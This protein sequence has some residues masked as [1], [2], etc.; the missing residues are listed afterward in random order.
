MSRFMR[1]QTGW[2]GNLILPVMAPSKQ[3]FTQAIFYLTT[4]IRKA[5]VKVEMGKEVTL[6]LLNEMKPDAVVVA[7]GAVPLIPVDLPGVDKP[8]VLTAPRC[9]GRKS[10]CRVEGG[11]DRS[12]MVR[13]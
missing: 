13:L 5:G 8:F 4:Q 3:E 11:G 6:K 1:S 10:S 2:G 9:S 12:G 7:T